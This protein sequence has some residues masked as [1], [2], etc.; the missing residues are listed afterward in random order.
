MIKWTVPSGILGCV[1][2]STQD[3]S[4]VC[5]FAVL[6]LVCDRDTP[7]WVFPPS[8]WRVLDCS[9]S[10]KFLRRDVHAPAWLP[11]VELGVR[12]GSA[13]SFSGLIR[14]DSRS[15]KEG[16]GSGGVHVSRHLFIC[17][18][19][20]RSRFKRPGSFIDFHPRIWSRSRHQGLNWLLHLPFFGTRDFWL[21]FL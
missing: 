19:A 17:S 11:L 9:L 16:T 2:Y 10:C 12:H 20:M 13:I 5:A 8:E 4:L 18:W 14:L 1:K 15:L 7:H 3:A 6:P 21:S